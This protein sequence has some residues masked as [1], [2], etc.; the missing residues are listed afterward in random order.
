MNETGVWPYT[1]CIVPGY[2]K[3][4]P[5]DGDFWQGFWKIYVKLRQPDAGNIKRPPF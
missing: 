4:K 1:N 5:L 2:P 3:L